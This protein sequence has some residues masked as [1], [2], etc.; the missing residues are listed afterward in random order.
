MSATAQQAQQ[1]R[2]EQKLDA[3]ALGLGGPV[4]LQFDRI[5]WA[6]QKAA[7]SSMRR[8]DHN[9]DGTRGLDPPRVAP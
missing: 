6:T 9:H 8:R 2:I 5:G 7:A 3:V 1:D 4:R